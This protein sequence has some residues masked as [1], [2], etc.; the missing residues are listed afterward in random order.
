M[1][2][3]ERVTSSVQVLKERY[4][5]LINLSG[6]REVTSV[7]TIQWLIDIRYYC[8]VLGGNEGLFVLKREQAL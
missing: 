4:W 5:R 1:S 2:D 8:T 6:M 3:L 7:S